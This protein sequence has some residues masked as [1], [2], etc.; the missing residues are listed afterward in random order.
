[1]KN[2]KQGTDLR[3]IYL[4]IAIVLFVLGTWAAIHHAEIVNTLRGGS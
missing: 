2:G 1:M 4:A 3:E